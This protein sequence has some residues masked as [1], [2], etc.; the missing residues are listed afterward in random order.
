VGA[1]PWHAHPLVPSIG[2]LT[3]AAGVCRACS[4]L[5]GPPKATE[6]SPSSAAFHYPAWTLFPPC[7]CK[8]TSLTHPGA[9]APNY[10]PRLPSAPCPSSGALP[11]LALGGSSAVHPPAIARPG[12]TFALSPLLLRLNSEPCLASLELIRFCAAQPRGRKTDAALSLPGSLL[13]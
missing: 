12:P 7:I 11:C 3:T 2:T 4:V 8:L 6:V 13:L 10:P 9:D 5:Q 1:V